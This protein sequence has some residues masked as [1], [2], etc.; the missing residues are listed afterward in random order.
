MADIGLDTANQKRRSDGAG[1]TPSDS[2]D[3]DGV[4]NGGSGTVALDIVRLG[5]LEAGL[6]VCLAHDDFLHL[7]AG[8]GDTRGS[9]VCV[10]GTAADDGPDWIAITESSRK[11]LDVNGIHSLGTAIAIGRGVKS[12]AGTGWRQDTTLGGTNVR[13]RRHDQVGAGH[14]G[15]LAVASL[16]GVGGLVQCVDGRGAGRVHGE[17]GTLEVQ[18][19]TDTV[20]HDGSTRTRCLVS[21][22]VVGVAGL[23][24]LEVDR[25]IS[26]K[27]TGLGARDALHGGAR[28]LQALV[29]DLQ[30][31]SLLWVHVRGFEVVDAKEAVVELAHIVLD[32]VTT[33]DIHATAAVGI[34]VVIALNVVS[35]G[36][37]GSLG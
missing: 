36:R 13:L 6:A 27:Y 22:Y 32:E 12:V 26:D 24:G 33:R 23:H 25:E 3:L 4:S 8:Q 5:Q 17:T 15:A 11:A 34:G 29:D 35:L 18:N 2:I 10:D 19:M 21:V 1:E 28:A 9:S 14:D 20:G 16:D 30:K 7:T 31:L 37:N